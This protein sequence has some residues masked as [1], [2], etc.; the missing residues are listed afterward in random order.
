LRRYAPVRHSD[1]VTANPK[2]PE[3]ISDRVVVNAPPERLY[4]MVADI[5][6][7]GEWSPVSTGGHW[8]DDTEH[9]AGAWFV[10]TN[11]TAERS[12]ETR[13]L[14]EVA[15]PGVEFR[16]VVGGNRTRWGYRFRAVDSGT[17]V[18][19]SWELLSDGV[20]SFVERFGDHAEEEIAK[21]VETARAGIPETLAQ[22]KAVAESAS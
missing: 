5:T 17:E 7:M 18:T 3:P 14:V 16:F 1:A 13:C 2:I 9:G 20:A 8:E 11:A 12:W 19:E 22:L 21:R 4:A 10:G 6:R 15:E